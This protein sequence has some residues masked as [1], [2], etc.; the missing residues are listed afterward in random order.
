MIR[1]RM[2]FAR[3]YRARH[4]L[5]RSRWTNPQ[6]ERHREVVMTKKQK[7]LSDRKPNFSFLGFNTNQSHKTAFTSSYLANV[8]ALLL[9]Y[10]MD[11]I[12]TREQIRQ[13]IKQ[14]GKE[15]LNIN[16]DQHG[17][18]D[19]EMDSQEVRRES[20]GDGDS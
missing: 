14:I 8:S 3:A 5:H 20:E 4:N 16:H 19:I 9:I 18:H 15:V 17:R 6:D 10:I 12:L 2:N 13:R 1:T 7:V 11:I